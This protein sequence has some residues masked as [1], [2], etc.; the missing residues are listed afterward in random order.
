MVG[1]PLTHGDKWTGDNRQLARLRTPGGE[2]QDVTADS[3]DVT[4]KDGRDYY[5]ARKDITSLVAAAGQGDYALADIALVADQHDTDPTYYGGFSIT[6]IYELD[7]LPTSRVALFTGT[8]WV[9]STTPADFKFFTGAASNVTFGWT[10]WEGDRA[11][12]GDTATLDGANLTPYIWPGD[13]LADGKVSNAADSTALGGRWANTL[14]V[15]AKNFKVES[16]AVGL[17][18]IKASSSGDNFLIGSMT[19]TVT[20][21]G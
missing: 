20:D 4:A 17:H 19:V 21:A 8:Q 9:S 18:T 15:D 2:Y 16:P 1:E 10:T 3:V 14:G 5:Q 13:T 6:V 7:S 11:L 12:R